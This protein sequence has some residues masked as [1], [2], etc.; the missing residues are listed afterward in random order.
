MLAGGKWSCTEVA[1]HEIDSQ[2]LC[3]FNKIILYTA[4][5]TLIKKLIYKLTVFKTGK[6]SYWFQAS[7]TW[8]RRSNFRG[9]IGLPEIV[10]TR[11][12]SVSTEQ[13]VTKIEV[14]RRRLGDVE[15]VLLYA[16]RAAEFED[17]WS[18]QRWCCVDVGI[19]LKNFSSVINY[20]EKKHLI[21]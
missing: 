15:R 12:W 4:I 18:S 6:K 11:R 16:L 21:I 1:R 5:I 2:V 13:G 9:N 10:M 3:E 14:A 20:S 17:W 19:R 7:T 8:R